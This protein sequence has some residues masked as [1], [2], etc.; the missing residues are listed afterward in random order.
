MTR[1]SKGFKDY[2]IILQQ[3]LLNTA[4]VKGYKMPAPLK[5]KQTGHLHGKL[6]FSLYHKPVQTSDLTEG[7]IM[8]WSTVLHIRIL[9]SLFI[10]LWAVCYSQWKS[11]TPLLPS[12]PAPSASPESQSSLV[13]ISRVPLTLTLHHIFPLADTAITIA[14]NKGYTVLF[15]WSALKNNSCYSHLTIFTFNHLQVHFWSEARG[16]ELN[17]P[18][19]A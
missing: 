18:E 13:T 19:L 2:T 17:T 14:V 16:N 5:P 3:W 7:K 4:T 12:H 8:F 15:S 6:Y 9:N 1:V 10:F 11:G